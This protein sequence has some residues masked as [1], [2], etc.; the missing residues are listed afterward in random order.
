MQVF[1]RTGCHVVG[2]VYG[3]RGC[4]VNEYWLE[5]WGVLLRVS[6]AQ[7]V[8]LMTPVCR[9]ATEQMFSRNEPGIRYCP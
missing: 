3:I 1:S 4:W 7:E 6:T 2:E 9:R 8:A 5:K